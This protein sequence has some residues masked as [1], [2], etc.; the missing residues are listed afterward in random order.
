MEDENGSLKFK[1]KQYEKKLREDQE[2]MKKL[3]EE[4]EKGNK[5]KF[6]RAKKPMSF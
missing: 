4:K 6:L 2:I 3:K 5:G 1:M